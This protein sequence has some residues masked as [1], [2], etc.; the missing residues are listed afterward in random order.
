MDRMNTLE[1]LD[2]ID[3][4]LRDKQE[5]RA[6]LSRLGLISEMKA[7]PTAADQAQPS[8][9]ALVSLWAG[10]AVLALLALWFG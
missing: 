7:E 9:I 8:A 6:E 2:I 4:A 10:V 5:G 3:A 1:V